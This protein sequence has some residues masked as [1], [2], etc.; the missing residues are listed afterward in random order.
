MNNLWNE[1]ELIEENG[2]KYLNKTASL[3]FYYAYSDQLDEKYKGKII[4]ESWAKGAIAFSPMTSERH[5]MVVKGFF[6]DFEGDLYD[7][8]SKK[9]GLLTAI[10][11]KGI[12]PSDLKLYGELLDPSFDIEMYHSYMSDKK[13]IDEINKYESAQDFISVSKDMVG[14]LSLERKIRVYDSMETKRFPN[15]ST[16]VVDY[17][18]SSNI[19]PESIGTFIMLI[20]KTGATSEEILNSIETKCNMSIPEIIEELAK[21]KDLQEIRENHVQP[22]SEHNQFKKLG[23]DEAIG[24]YIYEQLEV[25][26]TNPALLSR[27][28]WISDLINDISNVRFKDVDQVIRSKTIAYVLPEEKPFCYTDDEIKKVLNGEKIEKD[29]VNKSIDEL[30]EQILSS[31]QPMKT[32]TDII[33]ASDSDA[34]LRDLFNS[35]TTTLVSRIKTTSITADNVS[36]LNELGQFLSKC[37]DTIMDPLHDELQLSDYTMLYMLAKYYE[38][39]SIDEIIKN[40]QMYITDLMNNGHRDRAKELVNIFEGQKDNVNLADIFSS[41]EKTDEEIKAEKWYSEIGGLPSI[42]KDTII[43]FMMKVQ[44]PTTVEDYFKSLDSDVLMA[45]TLS[46]LSKTHKGKY[47]NESAEIAKSVIDMNRLNASNPTEDDEE[48]TYGIVERW[49]AKSKDERKKVL[50]GIVAGVGVISCAFMTFVL[51]WNIA[52]VVTDLTKTFG[53]LIGGNARFADLRSKL[54]NL[55]LYFGSIAAS[56]VGINKYYKYKSKVNGET[57]KKP[58][59][60][61]VDIDDEYDFSNF[62][63]EDIY[64]AIDTEEKTSEE[65]N[66]SKTYIDIDD[67]YGFS[68]LSDEDIYGTKGK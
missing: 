27:E 66:D 23:L 42:K 33:E 17:M 55:G 5:K 48:E 51:K 59:E 10:G 3:R 30:V 49:Q 68:D 12:F 7:F 50:Y 63:D 37:D 67:E 24:D 1:D 40:I 52:N 43:E 11:A 22:Y 26:K 46:L 54:G 8:L 25:A 60:Q 39:S 34:K 28:E 38:S 35:V 19:D 4:K 9:G 32:V 6:A 64:G 13:V 47:P 62:S 21:G 31:D 44:D 18:F 20:E 16:E 65:Q 53:N 57:V 58:E 29:Y 61:L 36:K 56:L 15:L 14:L 2:A 45:L 41:V